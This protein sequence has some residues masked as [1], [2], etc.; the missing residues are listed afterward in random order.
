MNDVLERI[1]RILD[2]KG[3]T[4]YKLSK[5][6]GIPY[7]SLN[8]LFNKNN[9]PT[10]STLEKICDG[11]Q[12]SLEDFFSA[13]LSHQ[14]KVENYTR[15]EREIIDSYRKLDKKNKALLKG[16]IDLL[17][18]NENCVAAESI[19][20]RAKNRSSGQIEPPCY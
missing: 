13:G 7:S 19:V 1:K 18:H 16:F 12:V 3:W 8:S 5:E 9:Q 11:L 15:E 10:I 17:N 20:R 6:T 4:L 14:I 2:E